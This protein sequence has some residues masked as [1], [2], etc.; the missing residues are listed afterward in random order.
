MCTFAESILCGTEH[1]TPSILTRES[2]KDIHGGMA[3]DRS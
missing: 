2:S 3:V 1:R